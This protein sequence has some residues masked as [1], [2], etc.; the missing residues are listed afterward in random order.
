MPTLPTITI[1]DQ[2]VWNRLMA[3]FNGSQTEYR[4]WLK[5]CLIEKV[6]LTESQTAGAQAASDMDAGIPVT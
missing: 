6:R 2:T 5:S 3:A 1:T 4:A